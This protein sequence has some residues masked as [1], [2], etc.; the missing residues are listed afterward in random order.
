MKNTILLAAWLMH[1]ACSK[2]PQESAATLPPALAAANVQAAASP[3]HTSLLLFNGGNESI[4]HSFRIPSIVKTKNGTLIA[5][6]EGRR[7]SPSDWGDINIVFKRSTNNGATWSALGEV[8]A[9][10]NGTWGNP[11]AVYDWHQGTNGRVWLFMSWN[12]GT[13]AAWADIQ[14]WGDRRVFS[15]YSDDHGA[16]WSTPQDMSATLLPPSYTWDAMGPGIGI[17]TVTGTPGRLIIPA[18]GRNIYSDDHGQTWHYQLIP[19][20]TDEGTIVER[21]DGSLLRNDRPGTTL[22]NAAK[23][24]RKSVGTIAGGFAAWTVDNT[25]NDP[26]CEGSMIRYNTDTPHRIIF[27][28]PNTTDKRCNMTVRIS[29]DDGATWAKSRQIYNWNTCDYA[30]ITIA[31]GGYSSMIKTADYCVGAL[32][33]INEDVH[34]S[35]TSNK[36][37]EFHKFNLPWILNGTTEP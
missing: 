4:Y 24:R 16:T 12:D 23:R 28:N 10:G 21:M 3:V 27:L 22:W 19:G 1:L 30:A 32:I 2:S 37:I 14:A 26:K 17:Q 36:S 11:T 7:W 8:A 20:G 35:S 29:Y 9:A 31:K 34:A 15:A 6:A 18:Y 13:K 25:L 5:F 33:E